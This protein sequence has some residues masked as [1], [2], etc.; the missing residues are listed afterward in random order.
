M[1]GVYLSKVVKKKA[2]KKVVSLLHGRP[3]KYKEEY[4]EMLVKHMAEG[5]SFM[6]FAAVIDVNSDTLYE[7]AKPEVQPNFSDAKIIAFSKNRLF[8]ERVGIDGAL[9][10]IQNFNA[11]AYVW[12]TKN[13]FPKEWNDRRE[14]SDDTNRIH[15]VKIELPSTNEQQVITMEPERIENK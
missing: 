9:G 5:F 1:G 8:W 12:N 2:K 11:T 13:R 7:W 14:K 6:S 10:R 4:C 15:T 3:T